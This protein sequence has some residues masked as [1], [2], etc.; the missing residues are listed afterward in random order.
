MEQS[1]STLKD[2]GLVLVTGANKGIGFGIVKSLLSKQDKNYRILLTS[3][4]FDL[5]KEAVNK[6]SE[7]FPNAKDRIYYHQLDVT[8]PESIEHLGR[9]IAEA[10]GK[11]DVLVNNAGTMVPSKFDYSAFETTFNVNVFGLVNLTESLLEK[12]LINKNG[13]IIIIGSTSGNLCRLSNDE[14]KALFRDPS[15]DVKGLFEASN[16]FGD[17]IKTN[18]T[19][20]EGWVKNIYVVSKIAANTYGK[21]L[22]NR[23]DIIDKGIQ[24]Y[25]CCP[26]WCKTDLAGPDAPLTV[27]Q[28]VVTPTYLI[29]LEPKINDTLQGKFFFNSKP[30][31]FDS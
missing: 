2:N 18:T 31:S 10:Y 21:M 13:K 5:V 8:D 25:A 19:E 15:L 14:I 16:K 20:S 24:A 6:L 17:S 23:K 11:I 1:N 9:H 7:Q 27:E 26:G 30:V 4:N 22:G 3:R 12:D 29:D 28:G